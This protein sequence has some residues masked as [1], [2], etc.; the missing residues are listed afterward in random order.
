[1]QKVEG[2]KSKIKKKFKKYSVFAQIAGID[3]YVMQSEFLVKEKVSEEIYDKYSS[4][5]D[6]LDASGHVVDK[7]V[8]ALMKAKVEEYGGPFKFAKDH[9]IS[10]HT[11]F[12]VL[13]GKYQSVTPIV[14]KILD[15]L[16]IVLF[17][18]VMIG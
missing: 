6:S 7:S 11:L 1:M 17:F 5:C 8:L 2:L 9:D 4:L 13:R 14:K 3:R 18:V 15:A 12:Q 10:R 16:G